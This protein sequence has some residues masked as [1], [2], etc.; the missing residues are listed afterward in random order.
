MIK[1]FFKRNILYVVGS[2]I[3]A[4]GGYIYYIYIGCDSGTCPITSS[5]TLSVVWGA[6]MG[7][8]LLS[9]FKK[10]KKNE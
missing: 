3:G 1:S 5:P 7:G 4:I 8:L 9:L 6:L 10:E 2:I